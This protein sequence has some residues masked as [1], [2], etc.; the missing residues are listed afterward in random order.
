MH[1]VGSNLLG[2]L[3]R[4]QLIIDEYVGNGRAITTED[5]AKA[6]STS[7]ST[8]KRWMRILKTEGLVIWQVDSWELRRFV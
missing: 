5:I 4:V 8:A 6:M 1:N 7:L 2:K 3:E